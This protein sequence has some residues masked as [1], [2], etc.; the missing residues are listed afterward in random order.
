[1]A[2]ISGIFILNRILKALR[3]SPDWSSEG[4]DA[5]AMFELVAI[6]LLVFV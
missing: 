2:D 1:M 5:G 4:A 3:Q 6:F